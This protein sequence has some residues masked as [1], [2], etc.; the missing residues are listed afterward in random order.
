LE[1]Q[2]GVDRER[3]Y[4]FLNNKHYYNKIEKEQEY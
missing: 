3:N 4:D 1:T 2:A